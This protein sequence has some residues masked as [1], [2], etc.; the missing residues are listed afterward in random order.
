MIG[1]LVPCRTPLDAR[2]GIAFEDRAILGIGDLL[3]GV[4]R[5]LPV[6]VVRAP[7]DVVDL[8]AIELEGDPELNQR[9]HV[10]LARE[11]AVARR[12][13]HLEVAG[14][15]RGKTG[16]ARSLNVDHA[17]SGEGALERALC[18]LLD[19]SPRRIGNRGKLAMKIIHGPFLL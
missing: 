11:D 18:L 15:N 14:S 9:F 1:L 4:L 7:L 3:R 12:R 10:A 17:P 8:L 6:R 19:A 16:A 2:R 13:D 5:R